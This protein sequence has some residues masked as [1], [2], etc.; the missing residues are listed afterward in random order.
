MKK[1]D[2]KTF[3]ITLP[4]L[5]TT[6]IESTRNF[7]YNIDK[8][9]FENKKRDLGELMVNSTRKKAITFIKS[10]IKTISSYPFTL[11]SASFSVFFLKGKFISTIAKRIKIIPSH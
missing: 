1:I 7:N 9:E 11:I 2:D 6:Q 10:N 3:I 8:I 4:P 5:S